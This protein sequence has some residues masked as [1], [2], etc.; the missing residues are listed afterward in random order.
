MN[1]LQDIVDGMT[2][3]GDKPAIQWKNNDG[4]V[5]SLSFADLHDRI[6]EYSK[7]LA[8]LGLE[9]GDKVALFAG[10]VPEW[11]GLNLGIAYGGFMDAPR[12]EEAPGDELEYIL[13]NS[14]AKVIIVQDKQNRVVGTISPSDLLHYLNGGTD[15]PHA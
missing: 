12:G 5:Q 8:G 10:N 7:G 15:D 3:W 2:R 6:L 1:T 9:K 4:E 11:I 13:D 14:E